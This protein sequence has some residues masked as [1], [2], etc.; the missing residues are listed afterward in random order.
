[1]HDGRGAADPAIKQQAARGGWQ[2]TVIQYG[3][4]REAPSGKRPRRLA[5]LNPLVKFACLSSNGVVAPMH[6]STVPIS[7]QPSK[8]RLDI[9]QRRPI[10]SHTDTLADPP[11][12]R[13][14]P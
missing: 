8:T 1:M 11:S 4:D 2:A 7:V 10:H 3:L 9:G 14:H 5:P 6:N 13:H 12:V